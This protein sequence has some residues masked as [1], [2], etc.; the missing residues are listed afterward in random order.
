MIEP[1]FGKY[2]GS[3]D[4][5]IEKLSASE[6]KGLRCAGITAI[7][8]I[9][10]LVVGFFTGPLAGENGAFVGSPLL[11]GLIPILFVFFSICAIA[12]GF[13]SGS[14]KKS[15][16]ISKA[17]NKQMAAMGSY[18]SF[19]FFCG[20][21]QG[22]FNWTKLGTLLAI[23]GADILQS[24]GF[25]GIPLF[26]C[27]ILVVTC[28]N[29][30]MSSGSAKWA[31]FAPIFV[32]MFMLLGYHPGFTQ[33]LYRLG[34]SPT[35]AVTPMSPYIWMVLATAQTKYMKDLKIGTLISNLLPIAVILEVI[36]V[37]FFIIWYLIG[38]PIGPGVGSV[39]PAGIM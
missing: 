25:T 23:G 5:K 36:W 16:D 1:R 38:L 30:F 26:V 14:F 28:V 6:S 39:L 3:S 33:L 35:N 8:Y 12:F 7:I 22:L 10:I 15:G 29:I 37:V 34:D 17:M 18:I 19:C 11:K 27:F 24:A 2:E 32:P 21:F 9:I 13:G 20:Q 31:I 4:E